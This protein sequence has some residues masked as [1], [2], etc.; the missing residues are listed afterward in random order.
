MGPRSSTTTQ[1]LRL[2]GFPGPRI[3]FPA[4]AP[5]E[6]SAQKMASRTCR[7]TAVHGTS[8]YLDKAEVRVHVERQPLED[9]ERSHDQRVEGRDAEGQHLKPRRRERNRHQHQDQQR[10]SSR[11]A[12][13]VKSVLHLPET[14]NSALV[15]SHR[16][17]TP[18]PKR[19][20]QS[21]RSMRLGASPW[22]V[23]RHGRRAMSLTLVPPWGLF[24]SSRA[25]KNVR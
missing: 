6:G 2:S 23:V 25:G 15:T 1:R 11:H 20:R 17:T 4:N 16:R 14:Q 22:A 7:A 18:C 19:K 10:R 5:A 3:P 8:G 24:D 21:S 12:S 13:G 9:R